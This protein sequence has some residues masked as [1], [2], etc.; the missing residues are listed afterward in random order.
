M[1][2]STVEFKDP[3]GRWEAGMQ[4]DTMTGQTTFYNED[5]ETMFTLQG[6]VPERLATQIVRL[7]KQRNER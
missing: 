7:Y 5:G 6:P 3:A 2:V 1:S 4:Y